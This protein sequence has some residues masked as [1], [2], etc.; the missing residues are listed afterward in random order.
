MILR[1]V[2]RFSFTRTLRRRFTDFVARRPANF[3][4]PGAQYG[5]NRSD[6]AFALLRTAPRREE[7]L[8]K[9]TTYE[10]LI[11]ISLNSTKI[12]VSRMEFLSVQSVFYESFYNPRTE[13]LCFPE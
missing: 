3:V 2:A 13:R 6:R 7:T 11:H 8:R 10:N 12:H 9:N 1:A 4:R 5:P